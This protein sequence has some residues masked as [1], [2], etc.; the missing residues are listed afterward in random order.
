MKI[1]KALCF[2]ISVMIL[3]STC[4]CSNINITPQKPKKSI[5]PP[6]EYVSKETGFSQFNDDLITYFEKNVVSEENYIISPLSYKYALVLATLGANGETQKE[7]LKALNFDSIDE[8]LL[9]AENYT[10]ILQEFEEDA[11]SDSKYYEEKIPNRKLSIANSIWHNKD[12]NGTLNKNYIDMVNNKLLAQA[13]NVKGKDITPKINEWVNE[14]TNKLI[15]QLFTESMDSANTILVNTL[16]LK[17]AWV[18]SFH[19][20]LTKKNDFTTSD[21]KKVK[22]DFMNTTEYFKYYKDDDTE[23]IILP[24]EGEVYCV[25]VIGN[26]N[27]IYDKIE[28]AENKNINLYIPKFEIESTFNKNEFVDFFKNRG[29]VLCFDNEKA[30]FSNMIDVPIHINDIVQKTKIKTDEEGLEAAAV[31]AIIM[32]ENCAMPVEDEP[33][34]IRIDKAFKFYIFNH[35]TDD[36]PELLFYGNYQK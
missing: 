28:K 36:S 22:K 9:W 10:Y 19:E 33:L 35:N 26:T 31:T 24:L 32:D 14:K 2:M 1:K 16:Y 17:S 7:M 13:Y 27:G 15:P 34:E 4:A 6:S 30:D 20:S 29:A 11:I 3:L 25:A 5:K 12:Q 23:L 21:G 8:C 18:N